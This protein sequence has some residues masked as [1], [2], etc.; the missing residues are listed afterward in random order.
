[1]S[2]E[3]AALIDEEPQL[4][5]GNLER[6]ERVLRDVRVKVSGVD[7]GEV[8]QVVD[9]GLARVDVVVEERLLLLLAC[10]AQ[11]RDSS[12]RQSR[13]TDDLARSVGP[14]LEVVLQRKWREKKCQIG[15]CKR[16]ADGAD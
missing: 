9:D 1:M 12:E 14:E 16:R 3:S 6:D 15:A 10:S 4:F 13:W 7:A 5:V 2:D 11:A 8:G